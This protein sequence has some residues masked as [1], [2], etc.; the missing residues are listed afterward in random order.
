MADPTIKKAYVALYQNRMNSLRKGD[1]SFRYDLEAVG[2]KQGSK[3]VTSKDTRGKNKLSPRGQYHRKK[4][5]D[6]IRKL[7]SRISAE[8]VVDSFP[9][10]H[11]HHH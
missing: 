3:K 2:I 11:N 6:H 9:K 1:S 8:Q 5:N 10:E 4:T 7:D